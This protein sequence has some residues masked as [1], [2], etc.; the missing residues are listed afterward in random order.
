MPKIVDVELKRIELAEVTWRLIAEEGFEAT[1]MRRIAER[2]NCTTGLVTHYFASKD[3]LLLAA[4]ERG[5][6]AAEKRRLY[7]RN[8]APG[9]PVLR[10]FIVTMLPLDEPMR[11]HWQV[12]ISLWEQAAIKPMLAKE[13]LRMTEFSK[14]QLREHVEDAFRRK[15][16]RQYIDIDLQTRTLYSLI[17]GLALDVHHKDRAW[18]KTATNV[19]DSYLRTISTPMHWN[20]LDLETSNGV[21]TRPISD[22]GILH[23]P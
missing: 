10:E 5:I 20:A 14:T 12:W 8:V 11:L 7:L 3:E 2:A 18:D 13:W 4:V 22:A 16:L 15:H 23:S 21:L 9:L 1:T 19:I 17:Y 6:D